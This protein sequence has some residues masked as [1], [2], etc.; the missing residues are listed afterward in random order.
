MSFAPCAGPSGMTISFPGESAAYRAARDRLLEQ[1]IQLRRQIEDVA[2]ARRAL[3]P[4]GVVPEDYV[5]QT[6]DDAGKE[7]DVRLSELFGPGK[8]SLVI[9]CYMF[10][11]HSGDPRPGPAEGKF[12]FLPVA[13]GPCPS[14]TAFLDELDGASLH[15]GQR[16]NFAVVT[17]APIDRV[18]AFADERGWRNLRLLSALGNDFHRDYRAQTDDGDLMPMLQVFERDGDT[19]RHFWSSEM[20]YAP[21]DPGQDPRHVGPLEALWNLFD[22]TRPGRP[23]DWHEQLSYP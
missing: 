21:S 5:F 13:E 15:A 12:A 22:F 4:G 9:Y 18:R 16:L 3:P 10:P 19:I 11:R 20:L 8:D 1:E 17:K 2:A 14:C 6:V 7:T 23:T